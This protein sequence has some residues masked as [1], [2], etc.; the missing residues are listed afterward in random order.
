MADSA[1]APA[2][3]SD[4]YQRSVRAVRALARVSRVV[5]R[6]GAELNLAHYRVLSAVAS[7]DQRASRLAARLALGKPTISTAVDAL[8][9]RGLL[10]RTEDA[11]DQRAVALSLTPQGRQLLDEVEAEMIARVAQLCAS[12]PDGDRVIESLAWLGDALD[13]TYPER[14]QQRRAARGKQE[15]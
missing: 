7:G 3:P 10:L 2:P 9:R 4:E 8:C 11:E 15:R 13:A 6:A 1:P 14:Q 5:E 12:T